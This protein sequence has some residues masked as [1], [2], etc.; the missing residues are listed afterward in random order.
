MGDILSENKSPQ[1]QDLFTVIK[2]LQQDTKSFLGEISKQL[3]SIA[4]IVKGNQQ[5]REPMYPQTMYPQIPSVT[6][7]RMHQ[8]YLPVPQR[9]PLSQYPKIL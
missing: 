5:L 8:Q 7:P 2:D 4:N 3:I 6:M 9:Y 1:I